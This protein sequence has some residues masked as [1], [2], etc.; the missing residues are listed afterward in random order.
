MALQGRAPR[1]RSMLPHMRLRTDAPGT[2]L[3]LSGVH[4]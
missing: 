2:I 1:A 4:R 3:V